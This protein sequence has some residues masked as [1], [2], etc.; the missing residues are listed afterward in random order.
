MAKQKKQF[1][2]T[3]RRK[4][5]LELVSQGYNNQEIAEKIGVSFHTV[6]AHLTL[7][8]NKLDIEDRCQLVSWGF[9]NKVLK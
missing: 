4:E 6:K 1:K 9:R 5:I 8:F 7:M 2:M 3:E